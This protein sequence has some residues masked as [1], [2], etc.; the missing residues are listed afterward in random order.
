MKFLKYKFI[1]SED[2]ITDFNA[3]FDDNF[4]YNTLPKLFQLV[5]DSF[6]D[7]MI[8]YFCKSL[9][10]TQEEFRLFANGYISIKSVKRS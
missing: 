3:V 4:W 9:F 7:G 2:C 6:V 10:K 5:G 1:G 8:I